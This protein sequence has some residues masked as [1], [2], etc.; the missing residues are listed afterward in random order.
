MNTRV[1]LPLLISLLATACVDKVPTDQGATTPVDTVATAAVDTANMVVLVPLTNTKLRYNGV[2]HYA[3]GSLK[4]YMRFFE[5]GN[6]VFVGGME[7]KPGQLAALLTIDAP[8]GWNQIHNCPVVQ[9]N[10]SL[11][12]RSVG[13]KGVINYL[14][15]VRADGDSVRFL[16]ASEITGT[17]IIAPYRFIP[18]AELGLAQ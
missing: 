13:I 9:R 7:D 17:R 2:Y 14:G 18:D 12:I 15:E 11:F 4:Y 10:D 5:R 8:S 16:K 1:L 3:D 6:A